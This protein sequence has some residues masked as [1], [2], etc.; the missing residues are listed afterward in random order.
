MS[1]GKEGSN[2]SDAQND[3]IVADYF[4]M[5]EM[6]L[7]GQKFVKAHHNRA[8]VEQIGRPRGSIERKY[9]N[10]SAVL[11]RLGCPRI[12]GY[13]ILHRG[14]AASNCSRRWKTFF[15]C[16]RLAIEPLCDKANPKAN[17]CSETDLSL[18]SLADLRLS[19]YWDFARVDSRVDLIRISLQR[20]RQP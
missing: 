12:N 19:E 17:A 1:E 9:M 8:L 7:A 11:E 2:W 13:T 5:L 14:Q 15:R 18:V 20:R 10:I 4:S 16:G 3:A 6:E